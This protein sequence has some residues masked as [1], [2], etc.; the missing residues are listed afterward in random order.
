MEQGRYI[1]M[2]AGED[3]PGILDDFTGVVQRNSGTVED[4]RSIDLRDYFCMMLSIRL[5]HGA[6]ESL[7]HQAEEIASH[8]GLTVRLELIGEASRQDS[9]LYRLIISGQE[10]GGVLKKLS[11]LLRVLSI[12]IE[13][14]ETRKRPGAGERFDLLITIPPQIPMTKVREFMGQLLQPL[15]LSWELEAV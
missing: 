5:E 3:R 13:S 8:G 14:M 7:K 4:V 1:I 11:H 9:V 2:I 6:F 15:G 12:N 10:L